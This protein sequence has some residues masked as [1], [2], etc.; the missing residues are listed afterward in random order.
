MLGTVRWN[1]FFLLSQLF[2]FSAALVA[3]CVNIGSFVN[4]IIRDDTMLLMV[5]IR[6]ILRLVISTV[7]KIIQLASVAWLCVFREPNYGTSKS[8]CV[9][10]ILEELSS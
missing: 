10:R 3:I 6:D 1:V 4:K 5:A 7:Q 2:G 9:I 8:N